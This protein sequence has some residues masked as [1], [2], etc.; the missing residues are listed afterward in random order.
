MREEKERGAMGARYRSFP[1]QNYQLRYCRLDD[2][3][4]NDRVGDPTPWN[5]N[6]IRK[7]RS[8]DALA[9][10]ASLRSCMHGIASSLATSSTTSISILYKPYYTMYHYRD[11]LFQ[12]FNSFANP[13]IVEFL[14]FDSNRIVIICIMRSIESLIA[15][16]IINGAR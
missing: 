9:A 8:D 15:L 12:A 2:A 1:V 7:I 5:V 3:I 4:G 13:K 11:R 10:A 14:I 16:L 6:T